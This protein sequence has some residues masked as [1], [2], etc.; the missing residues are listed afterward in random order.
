MTKTPD[1][2]AQ[3]DSIDR[4]GSHRWLLELTQLPTAA[5]R[6]DRV[7]AWIERWVS[8]RPSLE[9]ARDGSGNL[10]IA[11]REG[12][13]RED[14][15]PLYVTAHL[16]HPAFVVEAIE[17]D[18]INEAG[19]EAILEFRGGVM[20][21]YF[22]D[23]RVELV[24]SDESRT[25]ATLI[26]KLETPEAGAGESQKKAGFKR[27]RARL[28]D[29]E[30]TEGVSVGDVAIWAFP[31]AEIVDGLLHTNAC[32]DLAAVAAAFSALDATLRAHERGDSVGEMRVLLTRAEEIGFVGAIGAC[33]E[34][35]IPSDARLIALENSRSFAESPIGG[36]PIVRVGDKVSVFD[37]EL[38]GAVAKRAEQLA[39]SGQHELN[40]DKTEAPKW[41]WQRKLMPG[42]ACEASAFCTYG[43]SATCV[44]L[45]LGNYHNM[46]ELD[47]VQA[48]VGADGS[49]DGTARVER[50]TI[51][52][53]DYDGMV[54]LLLACAV[55]LPAASALRD[56]FEKLY[57]ERAYVLG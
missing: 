43:F 2:P 51:A 5:G 54:D 16:D 39:S 31:R 47:K 56:R 11:P 6:E 32:D 15:G 12:W 28:D 10:Y 36:G 42:G 3:P 37:T 23:A 38:T 50:E 45:P 1:A 29:G 20:D 46:G 33:R 49:Y 24:R 17:G 27:Y 7:I 25:P 13:G 14:G 53:A 18:E 30:T 8:E 21:A 48:G 26:R 57:G 4:E 44:C 41:K 52:I 22:E 35:M 34:G 40:V 9:I 55:T 19:R